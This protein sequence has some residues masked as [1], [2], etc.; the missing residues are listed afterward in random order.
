MPLTSAA[1]I[2]LDSAEVAD[3]LKRVAANLAETTELGSAAHD[4]A[5]R[6]A[7]APID[8]SRVLTAALSYHGG[9]EPRLHVPGGAE[10]RLHGDATPIEQEAFKLDLDATAFAQ[11][12]QLAIQPALWQA[13]DQLSV[14]TDIDRWERGYCP[15]CGAWPAL[16]ELVGAEKRRVLRC[17]RCGVG[18]SWLVL[19]CPYCGNDD[20]RSLGTLRLEEP[21][22]ADPK[23]GRSPE[24]RVD[25]CDRC[26]GYLKAIGTFSSHSKVRLVAEDVATV[27]LDVAA[28]DAGY[29]RP[30]DVDVETAGIPRLAREGGVLPPSAG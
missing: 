11:L 13:V 21:E 17:V 20:H 26:H 8:L 22:P 14:L 18:W 29:R 28:T 4:T 15:V 16:A 23:G 19:L 10:P 6:L 30:G 2:S 1:S 9:A 7:H 25:V 3:E 12:L 5:T 27:E 24:V